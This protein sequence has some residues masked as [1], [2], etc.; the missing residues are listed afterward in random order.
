MSSLDPSIECDVPDEGVHPQTPPLVVAASAPLSKISKT[1]VLAK[2]SSPTREKNKK[3]AKYLNEALE[4]I[5]PATGDRK[6][7][8]VARK[9]VDE[10]IAG[11][12]E[13]VRIIA[14]RT[15]GKPV[16]SAEELESNGIKVVVLNNN[17]RPPRIITVAP[18]TPLLPDFASVA[19]PVVEVDLVPRELIPDAFVEE[20][21][22]ED[23]R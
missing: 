4:A 7:Q 9:V 1:P 21:T 6:W 13:A 16:P 17:L 15:D 20:E 23:Y 14:D 12:M 11:N 10:A 18:S 19:P 3:F 5:D 2:P 8:C 22:E